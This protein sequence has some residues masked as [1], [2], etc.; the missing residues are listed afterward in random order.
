MYMGR[1][2][3][4]AVGCRVELPIMVPSGNFV[5]VCGFLCESELVRRESGV[6]WWWVERVP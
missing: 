4:E 2:Y 5:A 6:V 1:P 3:V